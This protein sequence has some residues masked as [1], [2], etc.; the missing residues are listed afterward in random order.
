MR[1]SYSPNQ[2][3]FCGGQ[4]TT[5][6]HRVSFSQGA[7]SW[8]RCV[9]DGLVYQ[10]PRLDN[11]SISSLFSAP[12]YIQGGKSAHPLGYYDYFESERA[13]LATGRK[14]IKKVEKKC[15]RKAL[16]ILEV[17]CATGSLLKAARDRGHQVLGVDASAVFAEYGRRTYDLDIKV[18]LVEEMAFPESVHDVV[19]LQ[20]SLLCLSDPVKVFV[21]IGR[22]LKPGGLFIFNVPLLD[23]LSSRLLGKRLWVYKPGVQVLYTRPNILE[24]LKR[25]GL[26]LLESRRDVQAVSLEKLACVLG[27]LNLGRFLGRLRRYY[28]TFY[29]PAVFEFVASNREDKQ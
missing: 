13:R 11:R 18:G 8:V 14:K 24:L 6:Y 9:H 21:K 17:G 16:N 15:G 2:C 27:F 28:L 20:G 12:E 5:S 4:Q 19:F 10:N 3:P 25:T 7:V 1:F 22:L 26:H 29:I 23:T